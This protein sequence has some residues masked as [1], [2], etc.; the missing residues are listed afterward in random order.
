MQYNSFFELFFYTLNFSLSS[1]YE[2]ITLKLIFLTIDR[3]SQINKNYITSIRLKQSS[4]IYVFLDLKEKL[5]II[6]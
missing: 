3:K 4:F 5:Q 2:L 1:V 6:T